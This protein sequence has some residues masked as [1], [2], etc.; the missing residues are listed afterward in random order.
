MRAI[1]LATPRTAT[2]VTCE[3]LAQKY[4]LKNIQY[5]A[6][7][8]LP[9][10]AKKYKQS[11]RSDAFD[12]KQSFIAS[13]IL[14]KDNFV[15]K[16]HGFQSLDR[17]NLDWSR[18][19]QIV[20]SSRQNTLEQFK[21]LLYFRSFKPESGLSWPERMNQALETTLAQHL[22]RILDYDFSTEQQVQELIDGYWPLQQYVS[23]GLEAKPITIGGTDLVSHVNGF[24]DELLKY[25]RVKTYL[26][27]QYPDRC[28]EVSYE[29]WQQD[30]ESAA[31]S[32]TAALGIAVTAADVQNVISRPENINYDQCF[33]NVNEINDIYHSVF[34]N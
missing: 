3:L 9:F 4:Q 1:V 16:L 15:M 7:Q 19:D 10:L 32:L 11:A 14:S 33:T 30:P 12:E 28:H 8:L 18:F 2:T 6:F 5:L 13:H 29:M 24:H 25:Q 31:A 23:K 21:S 22:P 34:D 27:G 17:V 20:F 26:A